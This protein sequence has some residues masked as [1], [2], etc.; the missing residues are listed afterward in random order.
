MEVPSD[1]GARVAPR[2][3]KTSQAGIHHAD[4]VNPEMYP[5]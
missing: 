1:R 4:E 2:A 5:L 3:L